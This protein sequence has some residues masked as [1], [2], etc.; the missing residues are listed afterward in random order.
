MSHVLK[1]TQ[2]LSTLE[3]AHGE[4]RTKEDLEEFLEAFPARLPIGRDHNLGDVTDAYFANFQILPTTEPPG[5]W[6][7]VGD[8]HTD[9]EPLRE[10]PGTGF[11]I[12]FTKR[13]RA[14]TE[15]PEGCVYFPFPHYKDEEL[16]D[17][18]LVIDYP[19]AIGK[20]HK[21]DISPEA[22]GLI[23]TFLV[24]I[25]GPAWNDFWSEKIRPFIAS[26][27]DRL[28]HEKYSN[29]AFDY[30]QLVQLADGSQIQVLFLTDHNEWKACLAPEKIK[31]GMDVALHFIE[32]SEIATIKPMLQ[33]RMAYD[34][35]LASYSP[36]LVQY[37]DGEHVTMW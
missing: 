22:I 9:K 5:E 21:K 1:A 35:T 16:G 20:W 8:L 27:R 2:I 37:Q 30:A 3:D 7:L 32:T 31:A 33:L 23:S 18:L 11:S 17:H 13:T 4:K 10:E 34:I 28:S 14:N 24:F 12:S 15:N 25:I 26:V 36:Y 29:L 6:V 19:I